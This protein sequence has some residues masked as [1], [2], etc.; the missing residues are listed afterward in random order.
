MR[1]QS[2]NRIVA[3][4]IDWLCILGWILITAAVG[5]PLTLSGVIGVIGANSGDL[6]ELNIVGLVV[7]ILP[8]TL[9]FAWMESRPSGQTLGKRIRRI[10]VDT[11]RAGN[12]LTY[13]RSLVRNAGKFAVPW[14]I[15]HAAVI[16]I[17]E[18]SAA[19]HVPVWVIVLTAVAYV[20]PIMYVAS[21]F[22][23]SGRTP[24]DRVAGTRVE[25]VS[26]DQSDA[27]A[28]KATQ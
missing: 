21:L 7:M 4:L 26:V 27:F 22:I 8:V 11:M 2:W 5:V 6:L 17:F 1:R 16:C 25:S 15:G 14:T 12:P 18:A 10:H 28:Q 19:G 20:I 24:Y 3:W 9:V 23:G 13:R